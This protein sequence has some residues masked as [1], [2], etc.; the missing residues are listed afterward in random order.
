VIV[1]ACDEARL[2]ADSTARIFAIIDAAHAQVLAMRAAASP[3]NW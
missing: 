3:N 1:A 2:Y